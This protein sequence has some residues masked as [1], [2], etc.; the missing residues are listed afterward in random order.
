MH[1]HEHETV[2]ISFVVGFKLSPP[3]FC[4]TCHYGIFVGIPVPGGEHLKASR[5]NE[6]YRYLTLKNER[7]QYP[8][9]LPDIE[10]PPRVWDAAHGIS[11]INN[12]IDVVLNENAANRIPQKN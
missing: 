6:E 7:L 2:R 5:R 1:P 11:F 4:H 12:H 3:M 10:R 9:K 8:A